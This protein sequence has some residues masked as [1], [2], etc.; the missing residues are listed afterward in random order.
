MRHD[1]DSIPRIHPIDESQF[2]EAVSMLQAAFVHD[3]LI[4]FVLPNPDQRSTPLAWLMLL[5]LTTGRLFGQVHVIAA[6][7]VVGAAVWLPPATKPVTPEQL[8]QAGF[9]AAPEQLGEAAAERF[10]RA[11]DSF[12]RLQQRC[13]PEPHWYLLLLGVDPNARR[14]GYGGALIE[15][16]LSQAD[17][18]G[19]PCYLE[20]TNPANLPF[21]ERAGFGV[22][23]HERLPDGPE[24]WAMTRKAGAKGAMEQSRLTERSH[25]G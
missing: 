8:A 20:T 9:D 21:Y 11:I 10:G 7:A 23:A 14:R 13:M 18:Q 4:Q 24:A 17:E 5:G 12:A 16:V 22:Q 6:P 2:A 25:P 19:A 1:I 15:P 3:P